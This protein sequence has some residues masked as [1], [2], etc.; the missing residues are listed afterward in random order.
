MKFAKLHGLGNDFLVASGTE[1]GSASQSLA[2]LALNVCR[3]HTGIGADGVIFY[4]PTAGDKDADVSALIYNADGSR[5]EMSGN[6]TRCLAAYLIRSGQCTGRA[7]RIR[8][9]AGIKS[10][11]LKEQ[12][13]GMYVF[14]SSLG[15]P[16]LKPAH[17]PAKLNSEEMPIVGYALAVGSEV[18]PVT[19]SSMGN[20]HCSTFW[21]DVTRA[22]LATLGPAI[23]KHACF[24]N[25]TN[26][27]FV[28]VVD[29][30][31]IRVR[32]WERG[33]GITLSSGTG[34]AAAAVAAILNKFVESPVKVELPQGDLL[35]DWQPP[36]ELLLT[37]PAEYVCEVQCPVTEI[38][39]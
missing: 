21:P 12:Q 33:V 8:T 30:H 10:F 35:I 13:K 5:A 20:P 34:S 3:R 17:I 38:Y 27:E 4:E 24:P 18:V 39:D 19:V 28:E 9:V 11:H 36:R 37:G 16:D 32:F 23:E 6:G 25:R 26:V 29:R 31:C 7:L 15:S 1:A 22:P 14:E 2:R